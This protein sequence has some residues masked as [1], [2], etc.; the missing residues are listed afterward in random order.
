MDDFIA[1]Q[2]Q[3]FQALKIPGQCVDLQRNLTHFTA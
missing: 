1:R 3:Y 2:R